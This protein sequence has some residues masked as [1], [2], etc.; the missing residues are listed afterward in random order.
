MSPLVKTVREDTRHL[1]LRLAGRKL[2]D[3]FWVNL[4]IGESR[5]PTAGAM[6]FQE[7]SACAA[8]AT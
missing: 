4:S 8:M 5:K 2:K 1:L 6:G 3:D 7:I